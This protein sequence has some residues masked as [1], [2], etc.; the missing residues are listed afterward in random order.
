MESFIGWRSSV[1]LASIA[2]GALSSAA[3]T[4]ASDPI[5]FRGRPHAG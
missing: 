4:T 3:A 1:A 5:V 2:L